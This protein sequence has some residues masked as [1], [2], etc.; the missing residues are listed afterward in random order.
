MNDHVF[1]FTADGLRY[2]RL[3]QNGYPIETTPTLDALADSGA[4]CTQAIATGTGTRKSFPGILTSSYPLMYGGY[5]QLTDHRTMLSTVFDEAGYTTLGINANAQLHTRFGWDR[6]FDVYFDSEQ[7]VINEEI[8]SFNVESDAEIAVSPFRQRINSLKS[9]V[10]ERLD[11]DGP[12]YRAVERMY[13][14]VEERTPPHPTA[15]EIVDRTLEYIDKAP[16]DQPLFVFAHFMETHSPY[17]PPK[18][19]RDAVGAPDVSA[20]ELWNINDRY[21]PKVAS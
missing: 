5:A 2:D 19:Y 20:D 1:L 8:G 11:Q 6:G 10:Y 21:F 13:R 14:L 17:V 18:E 12:L 15:D 7:T 16:D 3:S 4:A 9:S